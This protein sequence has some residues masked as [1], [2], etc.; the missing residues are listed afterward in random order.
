MPSYPRRNGSAGAAQLGAGSGE[1]Q[2]TREPGR[3]IVG[4]RKDVQSSV[5][6]AGPGAEECERARGHRSGDRVSW[7]GSGREW[8]EL[9]V[10]LTLS[11]PYVDGA[12]ELGGEDAQRLASAVLAP[13]LV[14]I[15]EAAGVPALEAD[16]G[17]GERPFEMDV[18]DPGATG[19]DG[20]AIGGVS[21]LDQP[22]VRAEL[23]DRGEAVDG[24]DFVDEGEAEDLPH[25][26]D[27]L[28]E[29][30]HGG[31]VDP[32]LAEDG[33]L[34]IL[35]QSVVVFTEPEIGLDALADGRI[36]KGFG[37]AGAVPGGGDAILRGPGQVVLVE[38]VLDM[39]EELGALAGEVEAAAQEVAGRA[40]LGR[41][42]VRHGDG[43]TAQERGEFLGV[44]AVVLGLAAVNGL[45]V[46][47]MGEDE[48][49]PVLDAQVGEPVPT[50]DALDADDEILAV[51]CDGPEKG[52]AR[53]GDAPV[54]D[55][56]ALM[57]EDAEV[58]GP[59]VKVDPPIVAVLAAIESH[60]SLL[61]TGE[62]EVELLANLAT[63]REWVQEGPA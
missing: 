33:L 8:L 49:D 45:Q 21:A 31:V 5:Q 48:V 15:G 17:L 37:E 3:W 40:H 4:A 51:G 46:E 9:A 60:G 22:S 23:L 63:P 43:A 16:G 57:V 14:R 34:E 59:R 38:G 10:G 39:S 44:D 20:L 32:C 50:E 6:A 54:K 53:A 29:V 19:A 47:C 62:R 13:E 27:G 36:A 42:D 2:S 26:V 55:D 7:A 61:D 25:A 58:H 24:V 52:I 35:D 11:P 56:R 28:E 30:K 18:A 12:P 41:V 1:G